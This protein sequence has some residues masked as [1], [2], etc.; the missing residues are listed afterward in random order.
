MTALVADTGANL[1]HWVNSSASGELPALKRLDALP[2]AAERAACQL[3][4]STPR[5]RNEA[6]PSAP[7]LPF[8]E[9]ATA[10]DAGQRGHTPPA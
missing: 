2:E 7:I 4:G 1:L 5:V 3:L 9:P 8:I 6:L 10:A